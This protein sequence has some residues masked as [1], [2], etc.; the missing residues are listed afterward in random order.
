MNYPPQGQPGDPGSQVPPPGG[1]AP[2]QAGPYPPQYSLQDH[3]A[4]Y[5]PPGGYGPPAQQPYGQYQQYGPPPVPPRSRGGSGMVVLIVVVLIVMI[6]GGVAGFLL[7]GGDDEGTTTAGDDATSQ[8]D[9]EPSS[10]TSDD[11]TVEP[12]PAD[13]VLV[14]SSLGANT[15]VPASGDWQPYR[16]PGSTGNIS[17]DASSYYIDHGNNWMSYIEVGVASA[18]V[19]TYDPADLMASADQ[20]I[21]YWTV[22]SGAF[23]STEYT[24]VS[25]TEYIQTEVGGL[26]AV[27]AETRVSW[28]TSSNTEDGFEDVAILLVDVDGVNGFIGLASVSESGADSYQAAVDALLATTFDGG[29]EDV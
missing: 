25:P 23:G 3:Q 29:G 17:E 13:E 26:P 24:R 20:A 21:A 14:V 19:M 2:G 4:G 28:N 5:E 15:P 12:P 11:E 8:S 27:L 22:D 6:G 1:Y 16:D 9:D 18:M 10:E 7:L